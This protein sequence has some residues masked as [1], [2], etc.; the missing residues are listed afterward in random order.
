MTINA[1]TFQGQPLPLV[2]AWPCG[3][4]T[5]AQKQEMRLNTISVT[6]QRAIDKRLMDAGNSVVRQIRPFQDLLTVALTTALSGLVTFNQWV[7]GALVAGTIDTYV[8]SLLP[9]NKMMA[10]YGLSI[11]DPIQ[12]TSEVIFQRGPAGQG[13]IQAIATLQNGYSHLETEWYLSKCVIYDP[14]DTVFIQDMPFVTQPLG[15]HIVLNGFTFE[16]VGNTLAAPPQ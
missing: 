3:E 7:T 6:L 8:N 5:Q 1:V 4:L 15:Q 9:N 10:F 12:G 2:S 11:A 13:G 14:Q 16:P